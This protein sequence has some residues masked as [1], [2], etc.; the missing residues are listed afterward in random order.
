[1]KCMMAFG[2]ES[3][4]F[5]GQNRIL[6]NDAW[7]D[8]LPLQCRQKSKLT[9]SIAVALDYGKVGQE[10]RPQFQASPTGLIT[11]ATSHAKDVP[12]LRLWA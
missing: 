11:L 9:D 12:S 4:I 7:L 3:M 5:P 6:L 8:R 2:T 10:Q 1:M